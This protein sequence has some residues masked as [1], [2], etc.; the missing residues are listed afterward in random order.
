M[1][2][3][4]SEF[5]PADAAGDLARDIR[6]LP[7][8]QGH[9]LCHAV[10]MGN[11]GESSTV[12]ATA[13]LEGARRTQARN[14]LLHL[15][16][17][18]PTAR[19]DVAAATGLSRHAIAS[20]TARLQEAGLLRAAEAAGPVSPQLEFIDSEGDLVTLVLG[21]DQAT[22]TIAAL[23]GTELARFGEPYGHGVPEPDTVFDALAAVLRRALA[24]VG[25]LGG[26]LI[27]LTVVVPSAVAGEPQLVVSD[28]AFGWGT[29]DVLGAVHA[30]LPQLAELTERLP[31][32]MRLVSDGSAAALAEHSL[33][34]GVDDLIYLAS[35]ASVSGAIISGGRLVTGG[36][37]LAGDLAHVPIDV[38]GVRCGCGQRGCL[39]TVAG[40]D[41]VL[42]RA[43]LTGLAHEAGRAASLEEFV[44]LVRA[45]D[46]R[47]NWSWLDASLWIGRTL[48]VLAMSVDPS[49]IVIGGFWAELPEEIVRSFQANRPVLGG[50][51]LTDIPPIVL[52]AGGRDAA[53]AGARQAAREHV[54]DARLGSA[55]PAR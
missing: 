49:A 40:P 7:S 13:V 22:A 5:E 54:I 47:A 16:T 34:P 4:T 19:V 26:R 31:R 50:E 32:G 51:P 9:A 36:H 53:V 39:I 35:D 1:P 45:G 27:D 10:G 41:I 38:D 52:A 33:L 46:D 44:A 15:A 28:S 17:E 6:R 55:F 43:G 8:P 21:A 37:G 29:V 30:R 12:T 42:D 14:V 3:A 2:R 11:S 18:G 20:L 25:R 48:Q 23:D 24:Q